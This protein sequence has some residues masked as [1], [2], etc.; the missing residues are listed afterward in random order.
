MTETNSGLTDLLGVLGLSAGANLVGGVARSVGQF[1][2]GV[3]QFIDAMQNF[4]ETMEQLNLIAKRVN[5]LLDAI[6]EPV[7]T[8]IPQVTRTVKTADRLVAQMT[9]PVEK[10]GP[11]L[12]KLAELMS[13]P[14]V[15]NL[16]KEL[17]TAMGSLGEITRRLGP[18]GQLAEMA[19][20]MFGMRPSAPEPTPPAEV[21]PT[22]KKPAAKKSTGKPAP[23]R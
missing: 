19:G 7:L 4:N 20:G 1:Q 18:L 22:P 5:R 14:A 8:A 12:L 16:P 9:V 2:R 23:K 11:A 10:A 3:T 13:S 15:R 21:P 6:E 17:T